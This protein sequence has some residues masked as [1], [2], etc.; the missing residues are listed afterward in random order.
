MNMKLRFKKIMKIKGTL[1]WKRIE[2]PPAW[3]KKE[4]ENVSSFF[5]GD[6][7]YKKGNMAYRVH[8]EERSNG[9]NIL[10]WF[11]QKK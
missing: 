2:V 6:R 4:H 8:M 9:K 5:V 11:V 1:P 7:Y 3:V 10:V